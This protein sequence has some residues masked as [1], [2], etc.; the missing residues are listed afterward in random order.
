MMGVHQR[1]YNGVSG[2]L[3]RDGIHSETVAIDFDRLLPAIRRQAAAVGAVC[4]VA[5]LAG[6]LWILA[7]V[8]LYTASALVLIDNKR[9]RAVEDSYDVNS[10]NGDAAG[11]AV[12]SQAEVIKSDNVA[13]AVIRKLDL[14]SD[15][16]LGA[17][18]LP[19]KD[20]FSRLRQSILEIF[21]PS[22]LSN[23]DGRSIGSEGDSEQARLHYAADML[24]ANMDIRR[25]PHTAV[26]QIYYTSRSPAKAAQIANACAEAYLADQLTAKYEATKRASDWLEQR[27]TELKHK[28]VSTDLAA[29]KYKEDHG[30][31]TSG[32]KLVN[33]QQLNEINSQLVVAR[34]DTA[35]AE[36]RY[37]RIESIIKGHQ[38]DA[39]VSEAIGNAI[40]A[41]LRT[42]YLDASK[43]EAEIT[44]RLGKDHM[45]AANLRAEMREYDRLMFEELG[46][47]AESYRSEVEIAKSREDSLTASLQKSIGL[48]ASENKVLVGLH[49]LQREGETYRKL[50]QIYLQRYQEALQQQSFP[51]ADARIITFASIPLNPSHP[52]K[53]AIL[54]LFLTAGALAGAAIGLFREFRERG[55]RG[56]EQIKKD[57][58]L[59]CLG[60][61]PLLPPSVTSIANR[62]NDRAG[63]N[64][65]FQR[66]VASPPFLRKAPLEPHS[67]PASSGILTYVLD[68]PGS[69]FSE[70]LLAVKLA[71]DVRFAGETSKVIGVVSSLPS[72]GKS[73]FSKNLGSI[74][75]KLGAKTLLIDGDLRAQ[76]LTRWTASSAEAGLVEAVLNEQPFTDLLWAEEGS[77]L[78]IL[79]TVIPSRPSHTSEF[80]ASTGMKKLLEQASAQFDYVV[81]DLPPLGPVV[82]AR[83]IAP[84]IGAFVLIVEW[85]RTPRQMVRN[86]LSNESELYRKCLGVVLNKVNMNELKLFETFG[87]KYFYYKDYAKSYYHE[88]TDAPGIGGPVLYMKDST[89]NEHDT[90]NTSVQVRSN[91]QV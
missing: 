40:I 26:L 85:R 36:A 19:K 5:L 1:D 78:L 77:G 42:R 21:H 89:E 34:S 84:R 12:D 16:E 74:L 20:L 66:A 91:G 30:L 82:D 39:I 11:S 88:V 38:T 69:G 29:Q 18:S 55:F 54:L 52:K 61:L 65:A 68:N 62:K 67:I 15:P 83:A 25:V 86:I 79:P 50:Y 46:R 44:V 24:R 90:K 81:I 37:Q 32:G 27:M 63:K 31:I 14:L 80:L 47:L 3:L 53:T 75:A 70:A 35:H 4:L 71:A 76:T 23:A 72:E 56:E 10:P 17:M 57:L 8:P 6:T 41:Q 60:I 87:S 43:R 9:V 33:E 64:L 2:A 49:E 59:E 73:V 13:V 22:S 28:A 7:S 48:N 45:Q 51:I 58:E